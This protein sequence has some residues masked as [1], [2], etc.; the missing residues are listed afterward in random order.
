M[1]RRGCRGRVVI[2]YNTTT[3][4]SS[5]SFQTL[6]GS[7]PWGVAPQAYRKSHRDRSSGQSPSLSTKTSSSS[8]PGSLKL[9][10]A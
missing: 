6:D 5:G 3:V 2:H 7:R 1:G 9:R 10:G 8:R 4:N